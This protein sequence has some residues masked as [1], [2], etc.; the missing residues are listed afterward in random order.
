ML[1]RTSTVWPPVSKPTVHVFVSDGSEF[2]LDVHNRSLEFTLTGAG[3]QISFSREDVSSRRHLF[4]AINYAA[5]QDDVF[6]LRFRRSSF[7]FRDSFLTRNGQWVPV[8]N[9]FFPSIPEL[10]F[11]LQPFRFLFGNEV[12]AEFSDVVDRLPCLLLVCILWARRW[13]ED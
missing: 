7:L 1:I 8:P 10:G 2:R 6:I 3:V 13:G 4:S 9:A 5:K 12:H 11:R